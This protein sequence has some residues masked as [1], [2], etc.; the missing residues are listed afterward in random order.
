MTAAAAFH[1]SSSPYERG[2]HTQSTD[3]AESLRRDME[4]HT[5]LIPTTTA[6]IPF[7][8]MKTL[9]NTP[10]TKETATRANEEPD[11]TPAKTTKKRT[12]T[13]KSKAPIE[14]QMFAVRSISEN[15]TP[16]ERLAKGSELGFKS[17][18]PKAPKAPKRKAQQQVKNPAPV[19]K[20]NKTKARVSTT[21][22]SAREI[23]LLTGVE[24]NEKNTD[25]RKT[26]ASSKAGDETADGPDA[27]KAVRQRRL[28]KK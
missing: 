20:R 4:Q 28:A 23:R 12:T 5:S 10:S 16:I 17:P 8:D 3:G 22:V 19:S 9:E 1:Y 18:A 27:G 11:N 25:K 7:P 26:R 6:A 24:V 15:G 2:R 13:R 21:S 14:N